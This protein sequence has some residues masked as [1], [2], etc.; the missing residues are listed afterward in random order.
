M[1]S[2]RIGFD[3]RSKEQRSILDR[4]FL[5]IVELRETFAQIVV[6]LGLGDA[7]LTEIEQQ[8]R[9]GPYGQGHRFGGRGL[10][11]TSRTF[12]IEAQGIVEGQVRARITA[13]VQKRTDSGGETVAILEW[14]GLR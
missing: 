12:R 5:H 13:I 3:R 14:S 6:A 1:L 9:L 2:C 11:V 7:E 10:T 8:R 4:G